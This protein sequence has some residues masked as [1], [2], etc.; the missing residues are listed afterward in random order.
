MYR[1]ILCHAA[2]CIGVDGCF[3]VADT[4]IQ[5]VGADDSLAGKQ[6]TLSATLT[7]M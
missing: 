6:V 2:R 7:S 5:R 3:Q 4:V 1:S